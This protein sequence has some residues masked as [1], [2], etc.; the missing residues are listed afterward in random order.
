MG[1]VT[2]F[3][4]S[5]GPP[6]VYIYIHV[7]I[8]IYVH[9]SLISTL[10]NYVPIF[11]AAQARSRTGSNVVRGSC[12]P[13]NMAFPAFLCVPWN[14]GESDVPTAKPVIWEVF[15]EKKG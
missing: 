9:T 13:L 10:R 14:T 5:R 12:G 11:V 4:T 2:L 1:V 7:Y 3:I 8:C 15:G 6:C